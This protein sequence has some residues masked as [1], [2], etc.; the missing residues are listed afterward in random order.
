[1]TVNSRRQEHPRVTAEGIVLKNCIGCFRQPST[2]NRQPSTVNRQPSTVNRFI[3]PIF[4][5]F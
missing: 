2:V 1:L 5:Y 3:L 4:R